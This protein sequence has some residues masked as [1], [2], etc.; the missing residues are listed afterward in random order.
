MRVK[1]F[2]YFFLFLPFTMVN[3]QSLYLK[4]DQQAYI[5]N[6]EY[7]GSPVQTSQTF[8]GTISNIN[9]VFQPDSG[10]VQ[11]G[12]G[13]LNRTEFAEPLGENYNQ[14]LVSLGTDNFKIGRIPYQRRQPLALMNDVL[15][16]QRPFI[17]G[18]TIDLKGDNIAFNVFTDWYGQK[19][20]RQRERFMIGS[21]M[22]YRWSNRFFLN[23]IVLFNHL[24]NEYSG[25]LFNPPILSGVR[26]NGA[27]YPSVTYK[28]NNS[29]KIEGGA[30][31]GYDRDR[32]EQSYLS[33]NIGFLS[34]LFYNKN[35]FSIEATQYA[36]HPQLI[37]SGD[38]FYNND[39][40]LRQDFKY[41]L[42]GTD[43][44]MQCELVLSL[45]QSDFGFFNQQDVRIVLNL[46]QLLFIN[47]NNSPKEAVSNL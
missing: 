44:F 26:D 47:R 39:W 18:F 6:R 36:G 46:D 31:M 27:I 34:K 22:T 9:L 24:A 45:H 33:W 29:V 30:L 25:V 16:Y 13:W 8:L 15:N 17:E 12:L 2:A 23:L 28:I 7:A 40:Y 43:R 14:F 37:I 1:I 32:S 5:S 10:K 41:D 20:I 11:F 35:R 21:G 42:F 4:G 19:G 38:P 3:G